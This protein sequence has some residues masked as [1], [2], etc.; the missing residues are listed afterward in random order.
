MNEQTYLSRTFYTSLRRATKCPPI[1]AV[2]TNWGYYVETKDGKFH[3]ESVRN[4]A[5]IWE[6]KSRCVEEWAKKNRVNA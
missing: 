3:I 6:A 4:E 5:N 2:K 1:I